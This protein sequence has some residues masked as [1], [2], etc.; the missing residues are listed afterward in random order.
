M[1]STVSKSDPPARNLDLSVIIP[2]SER[3]YM[4]S[5]LLAEYRDALDKLDLSYEIICVLDGHHERT[6]N[7]LC[8]LKEQGFG[9]RIIQ[10]GKKFGEAT[11]LEAGFAESG[12]D[13]I[14]TLPAYY[15]FEAADLPSLFD[16]RDQY[17]MVIGRRWPRT[18]SRINR[19]LS[20]AFHGI[21][22]WMTNSDF[23]DLSSGARLMRRRV[24]EEI[25]VYGDQ[26]RF[27]PVLAS[28]R[29]F[30]VGEADVRQSSREQFRRV[31]AIGAYPRR[32]LD[33]L[34]VFF[35]VKFTKKPLRFFGLIG[36]G[37]SS[38]G[39]L[40]TSVLVVQRL[41]FGDALA[42]RPALLLATLLIVLGVQIFALGLVGEILIY[43]HARDIREYTVEKIVN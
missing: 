5:D 24:M 12:G 19:W 42:Q 18:D 21:V 35:L 17:D 38:I 11:A 29:G 32:M 41:A 40:W 25:P 14:L 10:L 2:F 26:H 23:S 37:V 13:W 31:P 39:G 36:L 7:E 1:E 34:T 15:Q 30:R 4:L 3:W 28:R 8:E 6:F 33:L 16:L 27:L 43:T 22:N 20:G 9:I